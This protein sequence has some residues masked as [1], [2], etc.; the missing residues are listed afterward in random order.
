MQWDEMT[1]YQQLE[2]A[3]ED[4]QYCRIVCRHLLIL[5]SAEALP[6]TVQHLVDVQQILGH[7]PG[8]VEARVAELE[9]E[10]ARF[11]DPSHPGE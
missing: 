8:C 6:D 1:P 4:P 11:V 10:R 7:A 2:L 3:I 5:A 9:R